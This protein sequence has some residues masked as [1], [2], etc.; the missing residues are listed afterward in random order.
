MGLVGPVWRLGQILEPDLPR[1]QVESVM[2]LVSV[3]VFGDL[4]GLW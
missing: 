3:L 1:R 2:T 4:G